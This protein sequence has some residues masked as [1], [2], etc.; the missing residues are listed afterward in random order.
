MQKKIA[1]LNLSEATFGGDLLSL[2]EFVADM[3]T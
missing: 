3:T 2:S 1:S